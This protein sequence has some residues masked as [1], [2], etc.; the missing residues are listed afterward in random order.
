M[1]STEDAAPVQEQTEEPA[2]EEAEA[3]DED[4]PAEKDASDAQDTVP[5]PAPQ[6][7]SNGDEQVGNFVDVDQEKQLC[8]SENIVILHNDKI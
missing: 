8:Y 2:V 3:K 6:V 4:M 7:A 1:E 5:D